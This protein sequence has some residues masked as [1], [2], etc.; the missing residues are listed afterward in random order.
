MLYLSLLK[1]SYNVQEILQ[2]TNKSI[3]I[4]HQ[5]NYINI[6]LASAQICPGFCYHVMN[7]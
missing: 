6:I 2:T 1:E 7:V 3:Y 5:D 4:I